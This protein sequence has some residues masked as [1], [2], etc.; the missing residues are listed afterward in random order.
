MQPPAAPQAHVAAAAVDSGASF[1]DSRAGDAVVLAALKSP[2]GLC[3]TRDANRVYV[4]DAANNRLRLWG[5][6]NNTTSAV[7]GMGE[8]KDTGADAGPAL[9]ATL[10]TP[11]A[12][13]WDVL[14]PVPETVLY[15]GSGTRICRFDLL[16]AVVTP[17]CSTP[18]SLPN[19]NILTLAAAPSGLLVFTCYG[20]AICCV[21]TCAGANPQPVILAGSG[22]SVGN[23]SPASDGSA[24]GTARFG[25]RLYGLALDAARNCI[26]FTEDDTKT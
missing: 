2:T 14:T 10:N 17:L 23:Q 15:I 9:S 4:A 12:I 1:S 6:L 7:A 21:D 16:T 19:N 24:R 5:R 13:T 18:A 22:K 20:G 11:Y 3:V 25:A 26:W 8:S